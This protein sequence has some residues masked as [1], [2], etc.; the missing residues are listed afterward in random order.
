MEHK[1]WQYIC[2][3][4]LSGEKE[5][6]KEDSEDQ[7]E[8]EDQRKEMQA[9]DDEVE[10]QEDWSST[11]DSRLILKKKTLLSKVLLLFH[12][13]RFL[14]TSKEASFLEDLHTLQLEEE[15]IQE[16]LEEP[17]MPKQIHFR[18][19]IVILLRF[20]LPLNRPPQQSLQW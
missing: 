13:I 2:L 16:K 12:E 1:C 15:E 10:Q 4:L 20:V 9:D 18:N 5:V 6:L 17:L 19:K 11:D 14:T 3:N 7:D 8:N